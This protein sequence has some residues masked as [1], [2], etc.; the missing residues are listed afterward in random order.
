MYFS[1]GEFSFSIAFQ[2]WSR[3]SKLTLFFLF[4]QLRL[5]FNTKYP[6]PR[7]EKE[8]IE[9]QNLLY[10]KTILLDRC[11]YYIPI[12]AIINYYA[13]GFKE[14]NLCSYCFWGQKPEVRLRAKIKMSAGPAS[15]WMLQ[16][17]LFSFLSQFLMTSIHGS[18]SFLHFQSQRCG[19][20]TSLSDP[21]ILLPSP[22]FRGA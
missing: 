22:T 16:E 2:Q 20:F 18:L 9:N 12:S 15:C 13:G 17:R 19:I 14:T 6:Y 5:D 4:F 10:S 21:A 11:L 3:S 8:L 7:V 1:N